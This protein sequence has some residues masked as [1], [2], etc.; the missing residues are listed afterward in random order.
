MSGQPQP[1]AGKLCPGSLLPLAY[2]SDG[3]ANP[4]ITYFPPLNPQPCVRCWGLS[5]DETQPLLWEAH[6]PVNYTC[7]ALYNL[8]SDFNETFSPL[9]P[10]LLLALYMPFLV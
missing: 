7:K 10:A 1:H 9:F 4:V 8:L 6:S 3:T 2:Y 5:N